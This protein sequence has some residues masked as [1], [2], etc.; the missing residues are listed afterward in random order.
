MRVIDLLLDLVPGQPNLVG[1]NH[2]HMV[3]GIQIRSKAG[4][5]LADQHASHF[6]GQ[7]SQH[8]VR[9]VHYKPVRAG[10]QGF[11]LSSFGYV[12]SHRNQPHLSP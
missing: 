1:I 5:I 8:G 4:L 2:D 9:G 12:R 10:F 6:G 7:P 11:R 3:T